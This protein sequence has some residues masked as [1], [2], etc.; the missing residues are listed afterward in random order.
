MIFFF[1]NKAS[2]NIELGL[3]EIIISELFINCEDVS[4]SFSNILQ[5]V[6]NISLGFSRVVMLYFLEFSSFVIISFIKLALLWYFLKNQELYF[7]DISLFFRKS[8]L[9]S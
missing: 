5:F 8:Y 7:F 2:N 1:F 9:K 3:D 4:V 6:E